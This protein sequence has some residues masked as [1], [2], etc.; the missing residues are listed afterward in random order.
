MPLSHDEVIRLAM[1]ARIDVTA[2]EIEA[3]RGQ[4]NGIFGL[5]EK[6]QA[7]D[8]E[9]VEPMSH[10]GETALRL[11]EDAVAEGDRREAYQSVAPQ[12]DQGLY[13]VPKVIE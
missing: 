5:I 3:V 12:V 6:L 8:T 1:L 2:A 13:L 7:A 10:P 4:L 9:G 11:R